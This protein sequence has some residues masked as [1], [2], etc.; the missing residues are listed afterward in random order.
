MTIYRYIVAALVCT[1][2]GRLYTHVC[3]YVHVYIR[4]CVHMYVTIHVCTVY[5]CMYVCMYIHMYVHVCMY[6][7]MYILCIYSDRTV[8][9][10]PHYIHTVVQRSY[11]RYYQDSI[12]HILQFQQKNLLKYYYIMTCDYHV[13]C[14]CTIPVVAEY[15][16]STSFFVDIK[17]EFGILPVSI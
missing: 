13:T 1:Y 12:N 9:F 3:M 17:N 5:V 14:T 7:C 11:N 8:L 16:P 6:V 10:S 2:V 15:L 4:M